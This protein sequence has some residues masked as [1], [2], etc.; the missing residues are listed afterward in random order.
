MTHLL[1]IYEFWKIA[2]S[3][4]GPKFSDPGGGHLRGGGEILRF[5]LGGGLDPVRH[6]A[7]LLYYCSYAVKCILIC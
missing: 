6:Y 3:G 7:S 5:C 1:K 2:I 4:A